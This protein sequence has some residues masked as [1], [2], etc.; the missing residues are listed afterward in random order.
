ME[1]DKYVVESGTLDPDFPWQTALERK[2]EQAIRF[3][4][5]GLAAWQVNAYVY[6][7][8]QPYNRCQ[9]QAHHSR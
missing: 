7:R 2:A 9:G 1:S 6:G 4:E 5:D 3:W 8:I